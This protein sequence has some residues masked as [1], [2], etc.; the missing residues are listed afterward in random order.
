VESELSKSTVYFDSSF[1]LYGRYGYRRVTAL[2]AVLQGALVEAI[3]AAG[4]FCGP[5]GEDPH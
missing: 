3:Q 4:P 2:V 1:T 5:I